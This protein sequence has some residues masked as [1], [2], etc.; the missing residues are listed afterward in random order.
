MKTWQFVLLNGAIFGAFHLSFETV[1]RFLPT[2][3]L[4]IVISWTVWRTRSL[5]AGSLMHFINNGTIV[6]LG[7]SPAL[8]EKFSDPDATLPVW[9]FPLAVVSLYA[10]TRVLSKLRPARGAEDLAALWKEEA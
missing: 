8:K 7:T 2:A 9:I 1:I 10:G 4:G 5:W 6:L 3:W